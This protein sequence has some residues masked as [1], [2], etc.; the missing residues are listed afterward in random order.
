MVQLSAK[1]QML[2]WALKG[3]GVL[4]HVEGELLDQH[5]GAFLVACSDGDQMPDIFAFHS[6]LIRKQRGIER[7]HLFADHGLGLVLASDSPL[8]RNQRGNNLLES[9]GKVPEIKGI[10]TGILCIHA[11]CA[12]A[13]LA[14]LN[15]VQQIALAK[16]GKARVLEH[17]PNLTI[18]CFLHIDNGEK[19]SYFI[20]GANWREW[21]AQHPHLLA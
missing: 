7:P 2:F 14:G 1:D 13:A 11:P 16:A 21:V 18:A 19:R 17:F 12:A 3:F 15:L 9:I 10:T 6:G 8:N 4:Q 5:E 20:K